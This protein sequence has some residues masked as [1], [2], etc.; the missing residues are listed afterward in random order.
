MEVGSVA[1]YF[2]PNNRNE[3]DVSDREGGRG[4]RDII[5]GREPRTS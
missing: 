3:F 1:G 4:S 5:N 2:P